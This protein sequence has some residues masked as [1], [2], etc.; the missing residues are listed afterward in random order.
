MNERDQHSGKWKRK[1]W[2]SRAGGNGFYLLRWL[3]TSKPTGPS[4]PRKGSAEEGKNWVWEQA[5]SGGESDKDLYKKKPPPPP[6][7]MIQQGNYPCFSPARNGRFSLWRNGGEEIIKEIQRFPK[8]KD[9]EFPDWQES[10]S[11]QHN[12]WYSEPHDISE[13][14]GKC[15]LLELLDSTT[16][17]VEMEVGWGARLEMKD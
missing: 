10:M 1:S 8:P 2:L 14:Q 5:S 9:H 13:P 17:M 11:A 6:P 7:Y 4:E 15:K 3:L 16:D 12:E